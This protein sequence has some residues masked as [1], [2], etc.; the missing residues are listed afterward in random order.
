MTGE[1]QISADL[2][3][4]A[5]VADQHDLLV[6][7]LSAFDALGVHASVKVMQPRRG[8][9][10]LQWLVLAALPLQSFL[11]A[12]GAKIADDAYQA[13]QQALRRLFQHK[14]DG[15]AADPEAVAPRPVVL[16]DKATG[17]QVVLDRDLPAEGYEQLL[18]LDLSRYRFGPVHYDKSLGRWRSELDEAEPRR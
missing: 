14:P 8:A 18:S 1:A 10:E 13:F 9:E 11:S 3:V 7:T 12:V 15:Q 4:D 2:I 6:D 17:I 5:T 16:Q